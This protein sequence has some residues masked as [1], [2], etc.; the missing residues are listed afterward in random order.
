MRLVRAD[1]RPLAG[2]YRAQGRFP[3]LE[4]ASWP[5]WL[6]SFPAKTPR[7][8][9]GKPGS[10]V[11]EQIDELTAREQEVIGLVTLGLTDAQVAE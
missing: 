4:F 8:R 10:P 7:P 2:F 1:F 11:L 5:L 9:P 3:K 6:V